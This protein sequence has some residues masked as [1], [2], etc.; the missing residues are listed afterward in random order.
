MT[1]EGEGVPGHRSWPFFPKRPALWEAPIFAFLVS[2]SGQVRGL[3]H[4]HT[5]TDK[6]PFTHRTFSGANLFI[7]LEE[8]G[9][10]GENPR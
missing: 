4:N 1:D 3:M 9:A 7:S 10:P 6:R 5:A 2:H 8:A